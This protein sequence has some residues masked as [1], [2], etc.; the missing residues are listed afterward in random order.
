VN[1]KMENLGVR[2]RLA[3]DSLGLHS[4]QRFLVTVCAPAGA[5]AR[6]LC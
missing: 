3:D 5:L 1:I 6:G 2:S 4:H